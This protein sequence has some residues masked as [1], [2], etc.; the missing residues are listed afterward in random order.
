MRILPIICV[1]PTFSRRRARPVN[2]AQGYALRRLVRRAI[3]ALTGPYWSG[4]SS[5]NPA[6][7][8][9]RL[10]SF[11]D[12]ILPSRTNVLE[13]LTKEENAFRKTINKGLKNCIGW[14]PEPVKE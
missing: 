7:D 4:T 6:R 14:L 3:T 8:S 1:A 13:V 9:R 11:A 2:K 12:D 5:R 10:S